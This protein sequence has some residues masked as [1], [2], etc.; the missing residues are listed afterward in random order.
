MAANLLTLLKETNL[1]IAQLETDL[2]KERAT[3][4]AL[5]E[6]LKK[7]Q[8]Q[9]VSDAMDEA[10]GGVKRMKTDG[11][12]PSVKQELT[13]SVGS[14]DPI[15][16]VICS[17]PTPDDPEE[18]TSAASEPKAGKKRGRPCSALPPGACVRC[19]KGYGAHATTCVHSRAY[20][21]SLP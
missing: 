21:A 1:R 3:K 12:S 2:S 18:D 11:A 20:R 17:P 8:K 19:I 9:H 7:A 6:Q 10:V 14:M 5:I 16:D 4:S 13:Q 15:E